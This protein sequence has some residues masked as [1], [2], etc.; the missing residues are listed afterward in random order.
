MSTLKSRKYFDFWISIN[1]EYFYSSCVIRKR[2]INIPVC[3]YTTVL[4]VSIAFFTMYNNSSILL[5]D[6]L[7]FH[8]KCDLLEHSEQNLKKKYIV[9]INLLEIS[10]LSFACMKRSTYKSSV[11]FQTILKVISLEA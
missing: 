7:K 10:L 4:V 3:S 8:T 1:Q 5:I 6:Y 11:H 2:L 9:S